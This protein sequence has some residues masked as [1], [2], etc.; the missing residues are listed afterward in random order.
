MANVPTFD[1]LM[2]PAL[3][4]LEAMGG[5]GTNE[6]LLNKIIELEQVTVE[7]QAV[8]HTDHR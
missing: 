7:V 4:A 3:R 8:E 1:E 6:E 2:W 5:S